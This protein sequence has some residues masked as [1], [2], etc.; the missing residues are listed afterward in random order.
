MKA[1]NGKSQKSRTSVRLTLL[2]GVVALLFSTVGVRPL[3]AA[4][5]ASDQVE[6]KFESAASVDVFKAMIKDGYRVADLEPYRSS[7]SLALAT[8]WTKQSEGDAWLIKSDLPIDKFLAE[9]K[10]QQ[11]KG[12]ALVDFETR[13]FRKGTLHFWG[14]WVKS[15]AALDTQFYLAKESFEFSVLY[16][17]M[18]DRGY[19]LIDF[20]AY[21]SGGKYLNAGIWL[22]NDGQEVRFRRLI[23]KNRLGGFLTDMEAIG[24]RVLDIEGYMDADEFVYAVE[25]VRLEKGQQAAYVFDVFAD[26]F[27]RKNNS[28]TNEGYRLTEF[29][30]YDDNGKTYYA[31][32]WLKSGNGSEVATDEPTTRKKMSLEDFRSEK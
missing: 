5:Y 31:G 25:W 19:R 22:K 20:E 28:Y 10:A 18:A 21:L 8:I 32:S 11:K 1:Q 15:K 23:H 29:E 12:Y 17:D 13:R 27:Y 3:A 14:I 6:W 26:E 30:M 4:D 9:H 16:G 24:F 7:R 2:G